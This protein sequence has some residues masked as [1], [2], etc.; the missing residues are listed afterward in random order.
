MWFL[1]TTLDNPKALKPTKVEGS[2]DTHLEWWD[3]GVLYV[4]ASERSKSK[5]LNKSNQRVVIS[6]G[7]HGNETAPIEIVDKLVE[8]ILTGDLKVAVDCLFIIGNPP[9]VI[10]ESRFV[11]ENLNRLFS[12]KHASSSNQESDRAAALESYIE[13]FFNLGSEQLYHYDLH[14]AIRGSELEKFAV[15]PY[16]HDRSVSDFQLGFLEKCGI[17]A[18]LLSNQPSGTFSYFSSKHFRAHAFTIELGKVRR[19]GENEMAKFTEIDAGLRNLISG[20]ESFQDQ[21]QEIQVF[22]VIEE[23]IKQTDNFK[24]HIEPDAKNFTEFQAGALLASDT[25]YEYRT[26]RDGERFVFPISNVPC[27][28]RAMLVVAPANT[29][30]N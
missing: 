27:G 12:G 8:D 2:L 6:S 10:Q 24:L 1:Q 4:K 25:N 5:S 28:Q 16:L 21:P 11:E 18:V 7:I 22:E 23:V 14:T 26:K 13:R 17:Q 3:T 30:N 15:Y 20:L 29:V 19:F 9:A